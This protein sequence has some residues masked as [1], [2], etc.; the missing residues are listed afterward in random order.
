[1]PE[2]DYCH[3]CGKHRDL[4]SAEELVLHNFSSIKPTKTKGN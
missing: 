4:H 1:M 3:T 2:K